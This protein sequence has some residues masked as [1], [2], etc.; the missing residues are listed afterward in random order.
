MQEHRTKINENGRL[1]IPAIYRKALDIKAGDEVILRL[2]E[3]ELHI[4]NTKHA[5]KRARQLVKQY[6]G[7][8]TNLT[9]SLIN[10]RR[11]EHS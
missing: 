9:D 8:K 7:V 2:E 6:I 11:K 5:L 4:S 10:D 1:V 3:D